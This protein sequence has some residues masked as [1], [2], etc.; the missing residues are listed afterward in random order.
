MTPG[1]VILWTLAG[2]VLGVSLTVLLAFVLG[3]IRT[4]RARDSW[5]D[6]LA[7][8]IDTTER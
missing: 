6:A 1:L 2:L 3:V 4:A 7:R 5:D 8:L